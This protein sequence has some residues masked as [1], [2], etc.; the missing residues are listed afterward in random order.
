[1]PLGQIKGHGALAHLFV[2][3][4]QDVGA[5]PNGQYLGQSQL[6]RIEPAYGSPSGVRIDAEKNSE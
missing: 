5:G 1:M 4:R 2:D 6:W 3:E